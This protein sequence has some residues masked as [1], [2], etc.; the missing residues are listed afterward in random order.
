MQSIRENDFECLASTGVS[1][2]QCF[3]TGL[4]SISMSRKPTRHFY[5]RRALGGFLRLG[6]T[7]ISNG[8]SHLKAGDGAE[9]QF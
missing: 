2:K 7:V 9:S 5:L 1:Q 3:Q 6:E 8:V 4:G